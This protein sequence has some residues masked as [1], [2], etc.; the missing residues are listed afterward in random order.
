MKE[1]EELAKRV[2]EQ[3]DLS[4]DAEGVKIIERFR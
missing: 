2:K 1:L 4:Y 3:L